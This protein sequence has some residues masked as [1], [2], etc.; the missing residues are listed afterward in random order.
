MRVDLDSKRQV[1]LPL[2]FEAA[3]HQY[4]NVHD[5]TAPINHEQLL[6]AIISKAHHRSV[7]RKTYAL[8]ADQVLSKTL[9]HPPVRN[10]ER[11]VDP[12]FLL[13]LPM[14]A[15]LLI[16]II[17]I[18][19]T[20]P[21]Y[22]SIR[23]SRWIRCLVQL[24]LDRQRQRQQHQANPTSDGGDDSN[25]QVSEDDDPPHRILEE[26][27]FQAIALSRQYLQDRAERGGGR[28]RSDPL[29]PAEELEWLATTL[30]NLGLDLYVVAGK[31]LKADDASML[32]D[33]GKKHKVVHADVDKG[34]KKWIGLA[35]RIADI[36]GDYPAEEVE[37]GT[38]S[39]DRGL[40]S[41]VLRRKVREGLGW[42]EEWE[43]GGVGVV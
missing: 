32:S 43:E 20:L 37:G 21:D 19:R 23:A 7:P 31:Q 15:T 29:Y 30:F 8:F 34:A 18:I 11:N 13:P 35:M 42:V 12:V 17:S 39:G 16:Q 4:L 28:Q 40:L 26:I 2:E 27:I 41:R 10:D 22:D 6:S 25:H 14:A 9:P 38:E 24:C 5:S 3:M 36:L 1:L 33:G